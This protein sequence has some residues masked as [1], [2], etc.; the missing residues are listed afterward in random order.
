MSSNPTVSSS[1]SSISNSRTRN[2]IVAVFFAPAA[3]YILA[4]GQ[5][6]YFGYLFAFV[7][8]ARLILKL[9][10]LVKPKAFP[11]TSAFCIGRD[12]R[13]RKEPNVSVTLGTPR[14]STTAKKGGIT[15]LNTAQQ[16]S[17]AM[18]ITPPVTPTPIISHDCPV[19]KSRRAI[20][21]KMSPDRIDELT[22]KLLTTFNRRSSREALLEDICDFVDLVFAATSRQ[23]QYMSVFA[24][25]IRRVC[26]RI[27][28]S[29][30]VED[31]IKDQAQK[32]WSTICL[33]QVERTTTWNDLCSDDQIDARAR[34][35]SKQLAIAEFIGIL[36]GHELLHAS[37]PL[38]WLETLI[39]PVSTC[40]QK[41]GGVPRGSSTEAALELL[42]CGLR[43]LGPCEAN[44]LFTD[45]DQARFDN[46]CHSVFSLST[47]S[48]RVRC[49][50]QDLKDL[51]E[52]GWSI[53]PTWK[54]ALVPTKRSSSLK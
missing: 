5:A 51:R 10:L 34:H 27:L 54:Q 45:I 22:E 29:S 21:N 36:A 53:L 1:S 4:Y 6:S 46:L 7:L 42:C 17:C 43:G 41:A 23:P 13:L 8:V 32:Y 26:N 47:Q 25:L 20:L 38:S 50:I 52:S 16:S 18:R 31:I 39:V 2:G 11:Q 28:R 3:I 33:T 14:Q 44:F 19:R 49:I 48:S 30:D 15:L 37:F 35:R 24:Q 12:I 9:D 40:S